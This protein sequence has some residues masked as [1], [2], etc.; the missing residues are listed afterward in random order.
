MLEELRE[1]AA[2]TLLA[3]RNPAGYWTGHLSSSPPATA[4]TIAALRLLAPR[5]YATLIERGEA[6]LTQNQN[7]DGGWGDTPGSLSNISATVLSWA[8]LDPENPAARRAEP[9][10]TRH[11]GGIEGRRIA[12]ALVHHDDD[13]TFSAAI[14]TMAALRG[15]VAWDEIEAPPFDVAA[16]PWAWLNWQGRGRHAAPR[17]TRYAS[18]H[19]VASGSPCGTPP[20]PP[21]PK[22][23]VGSGLSLPVLIAIGRVRH[24]HLRA[25]GPLRRMVRAMLGPRTMSVLKKIQPNSGGF[26]E[27]PLH[28]ARVTMGLAGM[29]MGEH[30]V[31]QRGAEF[32][33]KSARPDGSWAVSTNFATWVTTMSVA[34]LAAGG[35]LSR[36]LGEADRDAVARW[37]LDQQHRRRASHLP[38]PPHTGAAAGGWACTDQS[39]G[40]PGADFTAGALLALAHLQEA[41][42]PDAVVDPVWRE[43]V[44]MG[45]RSLLRLQNRDGG[46]PSFYRE[47]SCPAVTAH[48]IRAWRAWGGAVLGGRTEKRMELARLAAYFYLEDSRSKDGS[49]VPLGF[50]HEHEP[51]GA[52]PVYGTSRVMLADHSA[53]AAI[54]LVDQQHEGGGWGGRR[55]SGVAN[56]EETAMAITGL[57]EVLTKGCVEC[58][59]PP[60]RPITEEEVRRAVWRGVRWLME[61]TE[62]GRVFEPAPIGRAFAERLLPVIAVVEACERL[63]GMMGGG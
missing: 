2:A 57:V 60:E 9:W 39:G 26:M 41:K 44:E 1:R 58:G 30:P 45:V 8:A 15:R 40:V 63:G 4:T 56:I 25:G 52:N 55:G 37:L 50:G 61:R 59:S 62:G 12:E 24:H 22:R 47:P 3:H 43:A 31:A 14:L 23:N 38:T 32:L 5:K 49:W 53:E 13:C 35:G 20:P 34:A 29:G 17:S 48:A 21:S 19:T 10:I 51:D 36:R 33:V 7:G 42:G 11:V 46:V 54:W 28:T 16:C 18:P 27:S 6:W